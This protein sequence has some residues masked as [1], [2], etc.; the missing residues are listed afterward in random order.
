MIDRWTLVFLRRKLG[1]DQIFFKNAY[2]SS[3]RYKGD[4]DSEKKPVM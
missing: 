2:V 4:A 3:A 1:E